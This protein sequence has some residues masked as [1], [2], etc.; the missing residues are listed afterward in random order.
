MKPFVQR[1][2]QLLD[3]NGQPTETW[4]PLLKATLVGTNGRARLN[5]LIDS[6]SN[7]T[8]IGKT[9]ANRLGLTVS[10]EEVELTGMAGSRAIGRVGAATIEFG[11]GR[12]SFRSRIVV[13]PDFES[14][15]V[16]LGV[17]DFFLR[18]RV[19]FQAS[20]RVPSHLH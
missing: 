18:H 7:E 19:V 4:A 11:F 14:H 8:M 13:A 3:V 15:P 5:M 17:R 9:V 10:N 1:F 16:L 20:E 6:G 2:S 12:Y